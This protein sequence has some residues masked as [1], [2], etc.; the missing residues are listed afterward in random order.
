MDVATRIKVFIVDDSVPIRERLIEL[1]SSASVSIV[2]EAEAPAEAIAGIR[3]SR[4][5]CVVLDL[6]LARGGSGLEVLRALRDELPDTQ[7]IVLS[8]H[9]DAPYRRSC[10]AAGADFFL[11]KTTEFAKV[12]NLI[13]GPEA[14]KP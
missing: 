10:V 3:R 4:P 9:T 5:D 11:D 12:S 13:A 7:F 6:K 2:G 1:L 8:N 14:V